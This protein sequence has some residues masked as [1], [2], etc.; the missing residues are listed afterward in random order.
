MKIKNKKS[1]KKKYDIMY[2]SQFRYLDK[3]C[4][5][6]KKSGYESFVYESCACHE[7]H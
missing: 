7:I 5:T 1:K 4:L 3:I 2:I 6:E